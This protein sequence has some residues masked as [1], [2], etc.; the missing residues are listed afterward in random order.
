MKWIDDAVVLAHEIKK[1]EKIA[2]STMVVVEG[3]LEAGCGP[4]RQVVAI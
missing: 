2:F 1:G 3:V 4:L